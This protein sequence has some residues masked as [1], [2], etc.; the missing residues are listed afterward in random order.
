MGP[1]NAGPI[2]VGC[3]DGLPNKTLLPFC[4]SYLC[5]SLFAKFVSP[6]FCMTRCQLSSWVDTSELICYW[7]KSLADGFQLSFDEGFQG[8]IIALFSTYC[9]PAC[10]HSAYSFF[11]FFFCL[12][13]LQI[14]KV[15]DEH[16][17]S[18]DS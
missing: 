14:M 9:L 7:Q 11:F 13:R 2:D 15:D 12:F 5:I 1:L 6:S 8:D 17:D 18:L 4:V 10:L 16:I 3:M